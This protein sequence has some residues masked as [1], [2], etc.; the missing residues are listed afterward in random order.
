MDEWLAAGTCGPVIRRRFVRF[1][2]GTHQCP[3][4]YI[5]LSQSVPVFEGYEGM[6]AWVGTSLPTT[7]PQPQHKNNIVRV[8]EDDIKEL[9][10]DRMKGKAKTSKRREV[11][12]RYQD[13]G[14]KTRKTLCQNK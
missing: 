11:R 5:K 14:E 8:M 1:R 12:R 7:Q 13:K 3:L 6:N 2:L 9:C 4:V 10:E